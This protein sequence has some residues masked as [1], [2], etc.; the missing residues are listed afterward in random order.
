MATILLIGKFN[1]NPKQYS[2]ASSFTRAFELLG[3]NVTQANYCLSTLPLPYKLKRYIT[4]KKI[5]KTA[6]TCKPNIIFILKGEILTAK[7]I[8]LL[9][10]NT[11]A[12]VINFYPDNPFS[13]WN[14]N[15]NK[16]I[17]LSL[18]FF[19]HFLIWSHLLKPVLLSAGAHDVRYFPFA[20]DDEIFSTHLVISHDERK[21]YSCDVSFIGTWNKEREIF[22]TALLDKKPHLKLALWGN[23]WDEYLPARSPLRPHLQG[24]AIYLDNMRKALHCSTITLNFIRRQNMTSHNM[25]TFEALANG[26][27]MLTQRTEEQTSH[28]F[29]EGNNIE[30]FE[31]AEELSKKIDFYLN[32]ATIRRGIASRGTSIAKEF[33]LRKQ[34]QALLEDIGH[35]REE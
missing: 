10:Q 6:Y 5:L 35:G 29:E 14:G 16:E 2:Y 22:L 25:R 24:E 31:N 8:A 4:N 1:S 3:H 7:T 17:L 11:T 34:L 19:D 28:P 33:T 26:T 20:Y 27:F 18:P 12:K 32:N 23:R 15:A 13:F 9:K 30:C 21:K